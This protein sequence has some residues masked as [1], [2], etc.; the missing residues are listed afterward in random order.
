MGKQDQQNKSQQ[1]CQTTN[2]SRFPKGIL[3]RYPEPG[4]E[5]V[6]DLLYLN[7]L[8]LLSSRKER[9]INLI[10]N[11]IIKIFS[12][13]CQSLVDH[14]R[15]EYSVL[16][17]D[18]PL[19]IR[20]SKYLK[21]RPQRKL[22][23]PNTVLKRS[24]EP[25]SFLVTLLVIIHQSL[26]NYNENKHGN[27]VTYCCNLTK[28]RAYYYA[29]LLISGYLTKRKKKLPAIKLEKISYTPRMEPMEEIPSLQILDIDDYVRTVSSHKD[30]SIKNSK[31]SHK[32]GRAH[33]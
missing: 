16:P 26:V 17:S 28:Q 14:I 1:K 27:F 24:I 5:K 31:A 7:E 12:P 6:T 22:T 11:E 29:A 21:P 18:H 30:Y 25:S 9:K 20:C 3:G 4:E 23:I 33:V 8:L 13:F 2:R 15:L 19:A 32:I 10:S